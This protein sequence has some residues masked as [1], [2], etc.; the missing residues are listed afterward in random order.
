MKSSYILVGDMHA[1]PEELD[2]CSKVIELIIRVAETED[3]IREVV[4]VGDQFHTHSVVRL[5]VLHW[6]KSAFRA[7]KD[8]GLKVICMVGNHDQAGPGS[9]AH[10]MMAFQGEITIVDQPLVKSGVLFLPYYH[11]EAEFLEAVK[12]HVPTKDRFVEQHYPG[13]VVCHQTF[14]GSKFEN[15]FL[16][17]DGFDLNL[18]PQALL[19]SGH[20]HTPQEFGKVWYIGAPRWRS[21]S[22]ANVDRAIW[23]VDFNADGSLEDRRPYSTGDVCRQIKYVVDTPD[24]PVALPIDPRHQWRID[25]KGPPDWCQTRKLELQAA[26]ARIRCFPTQVSTQ[27]R[28][29]ESEGIGSA[30]QT[31]L[32]SFQPKYG[33]SPE[34]LSE[35][36]KERLHV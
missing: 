3:H 5:E 1:V 27:G 12:A 11:T 9:Q 21:L 16:A 19:I 35:M 18:V 36:V 6:W 23:A 7:L 14:D 2:D 22:D 33:T 24:S 31:F 28:I 8:A 4:F 20:I 25:I 13:T 26:G 29:R 15:G 34:R 30:F 32:S 10:A 17:T